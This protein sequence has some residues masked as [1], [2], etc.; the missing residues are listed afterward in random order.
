MDVA[1]EL[2]ICGRFANDPSLCFFRGN[3][4]S[5]DPWTWPLTVDTIVLRVSRL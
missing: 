5:D 2:W 3:L 1:L 4:L